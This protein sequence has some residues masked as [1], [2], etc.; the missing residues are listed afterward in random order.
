MN[1]NVYEKYGRLVESYEAVVA[2]KQQL[3]A[4][5]MKLKS[6]EMNLDSI[7]FAPTKD[8]DD[9]STSSE[10]SVEDNQPGEEPGEDGP[11]G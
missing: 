3:I 9:P 1:L 6:G 4:V 10:P 5:L 11:G 2:E 8:E 7:N